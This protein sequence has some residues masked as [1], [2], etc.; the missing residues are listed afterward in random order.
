MIWITTDTHFGHDKLFEEFNSR[1]PDFSERIWR[2]LQH[3]L[4]PDDT[5]I[6][7]GD[8]CIG[9]DAEHHAH[10]IQSLECHR[11]I[12]VKGNHDKK[13]NQWYL[14]HGWDFVCQTFSDRYYGVKVLFSHVPIARTDYHDVCIHGH[15][16]NTDHRKH[17]P[18]FTAIYDESYH[19]LL[20]LE[21]N[22]YKPWSLQHILSGVTPSSQA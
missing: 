11:K 14:E 17:E 6:H 22:D 13:S 16:H 15:F 4:Q 12:L 3:T 21:T 1:P 2:A 7:L 20:A 19:K 9:S 8:I 10:Y 5:L 18:Y